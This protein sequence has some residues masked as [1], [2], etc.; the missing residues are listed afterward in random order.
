[1]RNR[2]SLKPNTKLR[3][4]NRVGGE[5][6][7]AVSGVIGRGGSCLVYDGYYINNAGYAN[8]VRIKECYPYKLNITRNDDGML[9]AVENDEK[10][11]QKYK[12]KIRQAFDV[13]IGLRQTMGLTNFI[14]DVFDIYEA[15]NT[16]YIVSSYVEGCTIDETEFASLKDVVRAVISTAKSVEKIHDRGYLYLDI[17]PENI[18]IYDETFDLI[19]LFDFD[20]VIPINADENISEY[21]ISYSVGYAP[22]EQKEGKLSRIGKFTDVYSLGALLFYLLFGRIARATDCGFDA[23]YDYEKLK[24]DIW[25]RKKLVRELDEFFHNTL[26]SFSADRYQTMCEAII[27]LEIIEK[28]A[29]MP[30]PFICSCH[31]TNNGVVVGREKECRRILEWYEGDEKLMFVTGMGGIGKST[32]VRKFIDDNRDKF[33]NLIYLSYKNSVCETIIDDERFCINGYEK[34]ESETTLEYFERKINAA[35]ELIDKEKTLLVIDNFEGGVDDELEKLLKL[36]WKIIIVMRADM[37][38]SGYTYQRVEEF[39]QE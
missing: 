9:C 36:N 21:K 35:T 15:S 27:Q 34:D 12:Q 3:F 33:D 38:N 7:Y 11:F 39:R 8:V 29:S 28:Y 30:A 18:F 19:Q 32:I 16:V 26:Q 10:E 17:K 5:M 2:K 22:I 6:Q 25:Y 24:W 13:A 31:V 20:S 14:S 23:V 37:S 4:T 1:M